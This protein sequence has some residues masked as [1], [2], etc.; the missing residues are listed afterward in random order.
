MNILKINNI[1]FRS[2]LLYMTANFNYFFLVLFFASN[3]LFSNVWIQP[4]DEFKIK[5][6]EYYSVQNGLKLNTTSYPISINK[7]NSPSS[8]RLE[9]LRNIIDYKTLLNN[10]FYKNS[11][12]YSLKVSAFTETSPIKNIGDS[13]HGKNSFTLGKNFSTDLFSIKLNI[14]IIEDEFDNKKYFFDNSNIS[15]ALGNNAFGFGFVD[16]WWGPSHHNNVILSNYSKPSPGFFLSSMKSLSFDNFFSFIGNLDYTFTLNRLEKNRHVKNPYL[17]GTRISISPLKN[18]QLSLNRTIT[19]GGEGRRQDLTSL[20]KAYFGAFELADNPGAEGSQ[21]N[22]DY[23]NQLAGFDLKYDLLIKD[24][25]FT[26]YAQEIAEDADHSPT[27]PFSGYISTLGSELKYQVNGLLRSFVLEFTRTIA[28]RHNSPTGRNVVYEHGS[29]KSGYRYRGLPIGAF[30]DTD[31]KYTQ[32]S[33]ISEIKRN[34]FIETSFYYAEPNTD[35]DGRSI[36]GNSGSPFYGLKTKYKLEISKNLSAEFNLTI[37]DEKLTFLNSRLD[38]NIL[39]F[40]IEYD[41]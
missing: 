39:G 18:L 3:S 29:Y 38:K 4:E 32:V 24:F 12:N 6:L 22:Y 20:Y 35:A 21:S 15:L 14:S 34:N 28:D 9:T 11:K 26:F 17:V 13:W 16:R 5:K 10:I 25:L 27:S 8:Y 36:W 2:I 40:T 30:I 23:S 7:L 31:S 37:A 33:F 19:I 1:L 41:F